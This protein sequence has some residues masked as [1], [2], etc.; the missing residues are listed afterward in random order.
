MSLAHTEAR[1]EAEATAE[2]RLP[3]AL[4]HE[5]AELGKQVQVMLY[6]SAALLWL[7]SAECGYVRQWLTRLHTPCRCGNMR[8]KE[9]EFSRS[10]GSSNLALTCRTAQHLPV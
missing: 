8:H 2:R 9:T 6:G 1:A 7:G 4:A 3:A 10:E 5:R